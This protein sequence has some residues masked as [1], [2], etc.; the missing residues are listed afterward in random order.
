MNAWS[1][2]GI[3]EQKCTIETYGRIDEGGNFVVEDKEGV[4]HEVFVQYI[5][6]GKRRY[7]KKFL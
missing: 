2:E 5:L 1:L 7:G 3:G 6:R 4:M